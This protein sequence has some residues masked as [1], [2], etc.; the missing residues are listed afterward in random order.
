[1]QVL[2]FRANDL[3][4]DAKLTAPARRAARCKPVACAY[5]A[6]ATLGGE[7]FRRP[8]IGIEAHN[9]ADTHLRAWREVVRLRGR[10]PMLGA[11]TP[12][13]AAADSRYAGLLCVTA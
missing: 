1:V 13:E 3:R 12:V 8:C 6:R 10:P 4:A 2:R 9:D 7:P 11:L 5:G